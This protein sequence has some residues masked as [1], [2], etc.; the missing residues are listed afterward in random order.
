M[1]PGMRQHEPFEEI[2]LASRML[3]VRLSE[4]NEQ[5]AA[6]E[7]GTDDFLDAYQEYRRL[8]ALYEHVRQTREVPP[9][10]WNALPRA[11]GARVE[12]RRTLR[13]R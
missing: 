10:V 4:T 7:P 5:M 9:E 2:E 3:R 12:G 8:R 11:S 13:N 1:A 6:A